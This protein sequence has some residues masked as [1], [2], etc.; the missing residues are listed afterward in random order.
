MVFSRHGISPLPLM[1]PEP[2]LE[3]L[4]IPTPRPQKPV[5]DFHLWKRQSHKNRE[6]VHDLWSTQIIG[7]ITANFC[8]TASRDKVGLR[9]LLLSVVDFT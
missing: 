8:I 4:L 1:H 7:N 3:A 5:K 2:M 9:F 6:T